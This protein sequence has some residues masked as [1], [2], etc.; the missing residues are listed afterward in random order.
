MRLYADDATG[1][2]SDVT[3][4]GSRDDGTTDVPPP[5]T[6]NLLVV[7]SRA[8]D[9][10]GLVTLLATAVEAKTATLLAETGFPGTTSD[11]VVVGCDPE[12]E[13]ARF[14]GSA[15][16]VGAAARACVRDAVGASLRSRYSDGEI[17]ETVAAAEYGVRTTRSTESFAPV[18]PAEPFDS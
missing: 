3:D 13:R 14:A 9:D 6:V 8:L 7:T 4:A 12:G 2:T 16:P 1:V 15:T 11:A 5:G 18:G 17:P 10:A